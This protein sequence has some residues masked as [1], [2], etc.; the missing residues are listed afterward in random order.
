MTDPR[1]GPRRTEEITGGQRLS[2]SA[3]LANFETTGPDGIR[4]SESR[5]AAH[6]GADTVL[7]DPN[8]GPRAAAAGIAAAAEHFGC[9]LAAYVD[10]G[11]DV[12]ARGDEPGL[13]SPLC[14][15]VMLA[16]AVHATP[17]VSAV[18]CIVGAG[19][20]GELTAD[21]VL[22]R[23]EDL[24]EL[25]AW[26]GTSSIPRA[27]AGELKAAART[28]PTEASVQTARCALGERGE[29]EI[30]GGLRRVVLT[31]AGGLAMYFDP[32]V[33]VRDTAPL[34]R[35]V[36]D[37]RD[38]EHARETLAELGVRTELDFERDRAQAAD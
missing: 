17:T 10:V 4:F 23:M 34:A 22:E 30:R 3:V 7:I 27:V 14:D 2:E 12:L 16:A 13:G 19:C 31:E 28:V 11:G 26:L 36:R 33:A 15:A 29:V 32:E 5:M 1:P 18:G 21:E 8:Q 35:A 38:L 6:L 24:V 9:D 20:D 25:G 37:A